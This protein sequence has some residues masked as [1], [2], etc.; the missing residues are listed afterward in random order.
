MS[1]F[2]GCDLSEANFVSAQNYQIN[3]AENTLHQARFALPEAVALLYSLD[4]I[5]EE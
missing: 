4:I 3:A 5:L 2:V 1:R